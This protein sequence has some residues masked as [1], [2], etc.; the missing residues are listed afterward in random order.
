MIY[1]KIVSMR[2]DI[3]IIL[4]IILGIVVVWFCIKSR[5]SLDGEQIV[6]TGG[7]LVVA[8]NNVAVGEPNTSIDT[9]TINNVDNKKIMNATLHTSKGDITIEFFDKQAPNTVANFL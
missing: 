3:A 2:K 8:P 1:D 5:A 9:K 7:S 4:V 6:N